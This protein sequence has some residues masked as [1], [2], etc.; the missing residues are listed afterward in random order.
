MPFLNT[1]SVGESVS[2]MQWDGGSFLG[3]QSMPVSKAWFS[4][5]VT[6][7]P[8]GSFK[9]NSCGLPWCPEANCFVDPCHQGKSAGYADP[10]VLEWGLP[11]GGHCR[12]MGESFSSSHGWWLEI[13]SNTDTG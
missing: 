12:H 9:E 7:V 3:R 13:S 8:D 10:L 6:A 11:T 2:E 4:V 1:A 5:N